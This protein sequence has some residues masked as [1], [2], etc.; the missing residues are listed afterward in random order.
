MHK[1]LLLSFLTVAI[2]ENIIGI[3]Y[4][5]SINCS[6]DSSFDNHK[7]NTTFEDIFFQSLMLNRTMTATEQIDLA[8]SSNGT[9]CGQFTESLWNLSIGCQKHIPP[10]KCIRFWDNSGP[11]EGIPGQGWG[12]DN[13]TWINTTRTNRSGKGWEVFLN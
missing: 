12:W 8:T 9:H 3:T 13:A 5:P 2:A 1:R 6:G 10:S 11:S 4:F 7:L